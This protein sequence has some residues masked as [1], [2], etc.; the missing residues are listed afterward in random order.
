MT[1]Y[2]DGARFCVDI[3]DHGRQMGTYLYGFY[4]FEYAA[5]VAY[6]GPGTCEL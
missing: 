6:N 1:G 2:A 4:G 3:Q 5:V